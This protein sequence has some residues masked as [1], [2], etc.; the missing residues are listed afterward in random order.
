[1]V[2]LQ[3]IL[4]IDMNITLLVSK[5]IFRRATR[6]IRNFI[7]SQVIPSAEH[8]LLGDTLLSLIS[9]A[10]SVKREVLCEQPLHYLIL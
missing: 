7:L 4:P 6:L 1:M 8:T 10:V 2:T 9:Q 5:V 3:H